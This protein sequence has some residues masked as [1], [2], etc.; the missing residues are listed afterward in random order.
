MKIAEVYNVVSIRLQG[1][2]RFEQAA[3]TARVTVRSQTHHLVFFEQVIAEKTDHAEIETAQRFRFREGTDFIH[4]RS[5]PLEQHAG[6]AIAVSIDRQHEALV[7]TGLRK[8]ADGM[9]DMVMDENQFPCVY[10][11]T[12]FLF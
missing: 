11:V 10:V 5:L 4:R 1:V 9:R 8:S 7:K 3:V 2:E 12:E 6:D